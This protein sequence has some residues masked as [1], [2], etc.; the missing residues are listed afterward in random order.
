M[1]SIQERILTGQGL[2][3]RGMD[4]I[5]RG[6]DTIRTAYLTELN[7]GGLDFACA[8]TGLK[9]NT[10]KVYVKDGKIRQHPERI[11]KKWWFCK[12]LLLE[13]MSAKYPNTQQRLSLGE[14]KPNENENEIL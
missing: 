3:Q 1:T 11:G 5:E 9:P 13:D 2:I 4:L 7:E 12:E 10:V 6:H 8:I 14:I